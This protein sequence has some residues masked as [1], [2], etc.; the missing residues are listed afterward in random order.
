M[1]PR[2]A[3]QTYNLVHVYDDTIVHSVVPID[4]SVPLDFVDAAESRR[5]LAAAGV[6]IEPESSINSRSEP[7]TSPI[8]VLR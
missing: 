6:W 5:R 7:P 1:A 4:V 8:P 2:D 3:A